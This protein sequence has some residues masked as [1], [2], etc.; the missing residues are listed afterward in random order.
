MG[1]AGGVRAVIA[2]ASP[3]AIQ[4]CTDHTGTR[5]KNTYFSRQAARRYRLPGQMVYLCPFSGTWAHFHLCDKR[6]RMA[7]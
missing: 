1:S 6:R 7:A 5:E 4:R 2:N 3:P